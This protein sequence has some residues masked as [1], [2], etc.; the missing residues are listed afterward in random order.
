MGLL[1]LNVL[2]SKGGRDEENKTL[3]FQRL[4]KQFFRLENFLNDLLKRNSLIYLF[5]LKR[6]SFLEFLEKEIDSSIERFVSP[7]LFTTLL[8]WLTFILWLYIY[9]YY[10]IGLKLM[11]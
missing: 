1:S 5:F 3:L 11:G 7:F 8:Y 9:I 4:N 6:N 2:R 10:I